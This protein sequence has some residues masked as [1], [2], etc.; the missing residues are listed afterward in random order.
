[1]RGKGDLSTADEDLSTADGDLR[2]ADRRLGVFRDY[3]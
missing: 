2:M 3:F 1:M